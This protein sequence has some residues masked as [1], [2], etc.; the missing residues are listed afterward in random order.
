M[1]GYALLED[2]ELSYRVGQDTSLLVVPEAT[3][4][5]RVSVQNRYDLPEYV[6]TAVLHRYWFVTTTLTPNAGTLPFWWALLGEILACATH[7]QGR[8]K[9]RGLVHAL[10]ALLT[11]DYPLLSA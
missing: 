2:L 4:T 8:S 10:K 1:D 5:H 11:R 3:L 9:L 6:Y 7:P